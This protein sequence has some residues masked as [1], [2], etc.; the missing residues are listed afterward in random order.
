MTVAEDTLADLQA[1][2]TGIESLISGLETSIAT[3]QGQVEEINAVLT[4]E[5]TSLTTY[6]AIRQDLLDAIA[7]FDDDSED[8]EH[9]DIIENETYEGDDDTYVYPEEPITA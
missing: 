9:A 6:Q 5:R 2:L 1:S 4:N 8:S 7:A 3:H